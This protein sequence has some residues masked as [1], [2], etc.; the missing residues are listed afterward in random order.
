MLRAQERDRVAA[1]DDRQR[2]PQQDVAQEHAGDRVQL[3][4]G[5]RAVFHPD[6]HQLARLQRIK[7]LVERLLRAVSSE[8]ERGALAQARLRAVEGQQHAARQHQRNEEAVATQAQASSSPPTAARRAAGDGPDLRREDVG[9]RRRI[10][11]GQLFAAPAQPAQPPGQ[12][13]KWAVTQLAEQGVQGGGGRVSGPD[14]GRI[15]AAWRP[16]IVA[17]ALA[18]SVSHRAR[19]AGCDPDR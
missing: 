13:T 16:C 15:S 19:P 17:R 18:V 9:H 3:A 8:F 10:A 1:D 11:A 2:A 5:S 12:T 6:Q 4:G 14:Q 7:R